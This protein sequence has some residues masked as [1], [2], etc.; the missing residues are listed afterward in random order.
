MIDFAAWPHWQQVAA[1]AIAVIST[2]RTAR[3]LIHDQLPPVVAAKAWILS[4]YKP[5]SK[6]SALWEC[7]FCMAPYLAAGQGVWL[8]LGGDHWTWWVING[9]WAGSYLA[10]ITVSYDQPE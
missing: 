8:W 1:V 10:A 7:Q 6:W 3:L 5:D 9:W 4:R 2:A